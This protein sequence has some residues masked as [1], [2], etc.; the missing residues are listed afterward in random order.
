MGGITDNVQFFDPQYLEDMEDALPEGVTRCVVLALVEQRSEDLNT[1][2]LYLID[3]VFND[4]NS[5]SFVQGYSGGSS[6]V[7]NS[8]CGASLILDYSDSYS[9]ED[10]DLEYDEEKFEVFEDLQGDLEDGGCVRDEDDDVMRYSDL[11]AF[12]KLGK[13]EDMWILYRAWVS[14]EF[15]P[16]IA[17]G[18][19]ERLRALT[20]KSGIIL[21]IK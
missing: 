12:Q 21:S 17:E 16:S 20:E 4:G 5:Y 15:D 2:R 8:F 10:E 18:D 3:V 11:S 6:F 19:L 1:N 14:E 9:E 7:E 13:E